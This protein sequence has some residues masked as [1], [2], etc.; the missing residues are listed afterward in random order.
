MGKHDKTKDQILS[1]ASDANIS[2]D[3]LCGC[4]EHHGFNKRNKASHRI[5]TRKGVVEIINL[6]PASDGKAKPYQVKQMRGIM[7]RYSI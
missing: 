6:Q 2:F 7:T 3:D 4:L 5:F 1:G